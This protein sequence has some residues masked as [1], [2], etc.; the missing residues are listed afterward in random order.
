MMGWSDPSILVW[1]VRW[2]ANAVVGVLTGCLSAIRASG[3]AMLGVCMGER[4]LEDA[5]KC[6]ADRTRTQ[7]G[8]QTGNEEKVISAAGLFIHHSPPNQS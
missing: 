1:P 3:F 2:L 4:A 6:P 5:G 8:C 7:A